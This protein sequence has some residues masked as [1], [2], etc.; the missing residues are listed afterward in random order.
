MLT[1]DQ[2]KQFQKKGYLVFERLIQGEKLSYYKGVFDD[3]VEQG[4]SLVK[5]QPH[6]TLELDETGK[7]RPGLLHKVQGVCVVDERVLELAKESAI[8][9]RVEA[10]VG[11]DIDAFGTKFFP[12]LPHGGTSTHWHQDNYYFGTNSDR[13]ISCGI[14]LEDADTENG[15]LRV[16]PESHLEMEIVEH[17]KNPAMHGSWTDV[18]ESQA[19]DLVIPAGTV[20]VFSANLL[21]GSNDNFSDRTRYSTAWHYLPGDLHMDRFV[22]GEYEDRHLVRGN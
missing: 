14:Y 17:T 4:R 19:I 1:D 2:V 22:R 5:E 18:D 12:K 15:C 7:P 20:V 11:P 3:L 6:W 16:I 21:H 10:L 9:D 8:L 13:I